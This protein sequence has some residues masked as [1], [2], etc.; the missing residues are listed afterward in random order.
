MVGTWRVAV[1]AKKV[2][3]GLAA[4]LGGLHTLSV[5]ERTSLESLAELVV[6]EKERRIGQVAHASR[7]ALVGA[8]AAAS[9]VA[10][11]LMLVHGVLAMWGR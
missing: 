7:R 1:D 10:T 8:H 2:R 11:V 9:V 6:L 3:G 5:A 4:L